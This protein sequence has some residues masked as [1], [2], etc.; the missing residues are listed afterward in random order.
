MVVVLLLEMV[1]EMGVN[2]ENEV[3]AAAAVLVVFVV[4]EGEEVEVG[5]KDK[6]GATVNLF[7]GRLYKKTM[8]SC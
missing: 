6:G 4:E 3:V 7:M 1:V 8:P 5:E 2:E